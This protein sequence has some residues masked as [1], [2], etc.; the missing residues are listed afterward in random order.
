MSDQSMRNFK[1]IYQSC[2]DFWQ[3]FDNSGAEPLLKDE[4]GNP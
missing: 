1:E 4:G 2:V 3:W